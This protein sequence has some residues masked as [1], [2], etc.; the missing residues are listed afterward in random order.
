MDNQIERS[1][2]P[3]R[4]AIPVA[5][6]KIGRTKAK[7]IFPAGGNISGED[8]GFVAQTIIVD[9]FSP[10]Y[11]YLP[12]LG[13]WAVPQTIGQVFYSNGIS[14]INAFWQAP[15]GVTQG[16]DSGAPAVL[17]YF[18]SP[19]RLASTPLTPEGVEAAILYPHVLTGIPAPTNQKGLFSLGAGTWSGRAGD[20]SGSASG[21]VLAC[22]APSGFT[23]DLLNIETDGGGPSFS[24]TGAGSVDLEIYANGNQWFRTING[25]ASSMFTYFSKIQPN[26][27]LAFVAQGNT[28]IEVPSPP[29]FYVQQAGG[30]TGPIWAWYDSGAN[31]IAA[32]TPAGQSAA[33][34]LMKMI[35]GQ[36]DPPLQLQTSTGTVLAGL[37]PFGEWLMS[38][39]GTGTATFSANHTI[40]EFDS[41]VRMDTSGGALTVTLPAASTLPLGRIW[42]LRKVDS[43]AN[44]VSVALATGDTLDGATSYSLTTQWQTITIQIASTASGAGVWDIIGVR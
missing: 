41:T 25:S 44:A 17:S 27:N 5:I 8:L 29:V 7:Q 35:T 31:L 16:I 12:D 1:L 43:S 33:T 6:Y 38:G 2:I 36:V 24:I 10:L 34:L 20:F 23:G 30:Q 14:A 39:V 18:E 21:T 26:S 42:T 28:V 19:L 4:A 22:N 15:P 32:I 9:N 3:E 11:L 40:S 37:S 13:R